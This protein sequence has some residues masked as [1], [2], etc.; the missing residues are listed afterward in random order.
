[1]VIGQAGKKYGLHRPG[2]PAKK[3]S[4]FGD[5]DDDDVQQDAMKVLVSD[6]HREKV[7]KKVEKEMAKALAEDA[8]I[9]DYDGVH[10]SISAARE[11]QA[12]NKKASQKVP[13][14][15]RTCMQWSAEAECLTGSIL[16]TAGER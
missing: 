8:S 16:A 7:Q 15:L 12:V 9:F 6:K 10:D 1:M 14:F 11:E 4:V 3:A 13:C 2:A 5:D